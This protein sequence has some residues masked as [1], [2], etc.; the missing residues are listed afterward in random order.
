VRECCSWN[1]NIR[2]AAIENSSLC[3]DAGNAIALGIDF[4]LRV[5]DDVENAANLLDRTVGTYD[6]ILIDLIDLDA[7]ASLACPLDLFT[8]T[9]I[10]IVQLVNDMIA[11]TPHTTLIYTSKA[12]PPAEEIRLGSEPGVFV[13]GLAQL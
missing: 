11:T 5:G 13:G 10:D 12:R 9:S 4:G 6:I 2:V 3:K 1:D 7:D 8:S